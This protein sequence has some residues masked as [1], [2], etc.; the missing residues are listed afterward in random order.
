MQ[1]HSRNAESR[2]FNQHRPHSSALR[3]AHQQRALVRRSFCTTNVMNVI[4]TLSICST[5][6]SIF[7][8]SKSTN[9]LANNS[10]CSTSQKYDYLPCTVALHSPAL[11]CSCAAGP[12]LP[13][14]A[15]GRRTDGRADGRG[16]ESQHRFRNVTI[17]RPRPR[18][19]APLPHSVS[20]GWA[21]SILQ[22]HFGTLMTS[23]G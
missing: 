6:K 23:P 2:S 20:V 15:T 7:H 18:P 16:R 5:T 13:I 9:P 11:C 1:F 3:S 19:L 10:Q 8:V 12:M 21:N 17:P 14:I 22:L 4:R